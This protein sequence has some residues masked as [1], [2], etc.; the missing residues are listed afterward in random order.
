MELELPDNVIAQPGVLQHERHPVDVVDGFER[1]YRLWFYVAEQRDFVDQVPADRVI[2]PRDDDLGLDAD[3]AQFADAVLRGLGLEFSGRADVGQESDMDIQRVIAPHVGAQLAQGFE[4]RLA[5]NIPDCA[6]D[7]DDHDFRI[8]FLAHQPDPPFD[9]V[10]DVRNDLDRAAQVVSSAFFAD[11]VGINLPGSHVAG[12]IQVLVCE[13]LVVPEVEVGFG[14]VRGDE[15]LAVLVGAHCAGIDIQIGVEF[16]DGDFQA[17]RFE[18]PA[19]SRC[20]DALANRTHDATGAKDV[21]RHS[22]CYLICVI[23]SGGEVKAMVPS[24]PAAYVAY[25]LSRIRVLTRSLNQLFKIIGCTLHIQKNETQFGT[26][27]D[28]RCQNGF[29]THRHQDHKTGLATHVDLVEETAP[30][31]A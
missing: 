23:K 9:L 19:N 26:L 15:N 30:Q 22:P 20:G 3:A 11:D 21:L 12:V 31:L 16:L 24:L 8:V 29:L 13:P 27:A 14:S 1:D 7:L 5:L 25:R 18:D 2:R 28:Q 17:A 10:G 6:T 4:K